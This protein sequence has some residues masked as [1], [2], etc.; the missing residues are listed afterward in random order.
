MLIVAKIFST[1]SDLV[2]FTV[3]TIQLILC[4]CLTKLGVFNIISIGI[5]LTMTGQAICIYICKYYIYCGDCAE[6]E[7]KEKSKHLYIQ[8]DIPS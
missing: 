5:F 4:N 1:S 8:K 3:T 6:N 2:L 7:I